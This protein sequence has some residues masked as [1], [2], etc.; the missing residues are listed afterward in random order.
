MSL[1]TEHACIRDFLKQHADDDDASEDACFSTE[2]T[3]DIFRFITAACFLFLSCTQGWFGVKLHHI[4]DWQQLGMISIQKNNLTVLNVFLCFSFLSRVV[5]QTLAIFWDFGFANIP[6]DGAHDVPVQL[7]LIILLWDYLPTVLLLLYVV[8][9]SLQGG[10]FASRARSGSRNLSIDEGDYGARDW[11]RADTFA[12]SEDGGGDGG[13]AGGEGVWARVKH[14]LRV[15]RAR[16]RGLAGGTAGDEAR[17]H[18]G[19]VR[20]SIC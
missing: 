12:S 9:P 6:L 7:F 20:M 4:T 14:T 8:A 16:L 19:E 10:I 1:E 18:S 5:Y 2:Y 17:R 11:D 3:A 15:G 13:E